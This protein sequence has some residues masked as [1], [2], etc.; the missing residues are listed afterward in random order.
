MMRRR[1]RAYVFALGFAGFA[2]FV[3][4]AGAAEPSAHPPKTT[5][6]ATARRAVR[7]TGSGPCPPIAPASTSTSVSAAPGT[8]PT[9]YRDAHYAA[10]QIAAD[11]ERMRRLLSCPPPVGDAYGAR[12]AW[13]RV[14]DA[15][16]D[17]S[18]DEVPTAASKPPSPTKPDSRA[19]LRTRKLQNAPARP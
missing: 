2:G 19:G 1:T 3:A 5:T 14:D 16:A 7:S 17:T 13:D 9:P 4:A 6:D 10:G 18:K 11:I 12:D 15:A 8:P